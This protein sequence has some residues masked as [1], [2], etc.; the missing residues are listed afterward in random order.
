MTLAQRH[1]K[2][3]TVSPRFGSSFLDLG[4]LI[5]SFYLESRTCY[6]S[7]QLKKQNELTAAILAYGAYSCFVQVLPSLVIL[8]RAAS[9]PRLLPLT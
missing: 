4:V 6:K 8:C 5:R 1:G 3:T 2:Y 9:Q 7:R